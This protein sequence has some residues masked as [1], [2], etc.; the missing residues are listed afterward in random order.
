[1]SFPSSTSLPPSA[2]TQPASSRSGRIIDGARR[3]STA[4]TGGGAGALILALTLLAETLE[5]WGKI[6][7][8]TGPTQASVAAVIVVLVA[9]YLQ[10]QE[11]RDE[12]ARIERERARHAYQAMVERLVERQ[13]ERVQDSHADLKTTITTGLRDVAAQI[14]DLAKAVNEITGPYRRPELRR[15]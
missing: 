3:S 7:S 12:E 6:S 15:G 10:R 9:M 11:R 5:R 14:G 13:E 2:D 8:A 4:L 1:M